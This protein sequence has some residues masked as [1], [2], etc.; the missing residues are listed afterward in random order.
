[1]LDED[2]PN[3]TDDHV[4]ACQVHPRPPVGDRQVIRLSPF[5][6]WADQLHISGWDD[7][8]EA[9]DLARIGVGRLERLSPAKHRAQTCA[10]ACGPRGSSPPSPVRGPTRCSPGGEI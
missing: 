1:M 9:G 3:A 5:G 4:V 8:E 6:I 2:G 7:I 10:R